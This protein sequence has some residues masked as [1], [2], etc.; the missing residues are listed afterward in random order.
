M[1]YVCITI[2]N[3]KKLKMLKKNG[4]QKKLIL[5]VYKLVLNLSNFDFVLCVC[6]RQFYVENIVLEA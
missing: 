3:K 5:F 2:D 6:M 4:R 1:S